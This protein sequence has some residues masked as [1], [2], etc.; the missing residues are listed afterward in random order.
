MDGQKFYGRD[1]DRL[2]I[3]DHRLDTQPRVGPS[4]VRWH[5]RIILGKAL[6]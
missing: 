5:V 3:V 2:D 4:E 6:T 1:A